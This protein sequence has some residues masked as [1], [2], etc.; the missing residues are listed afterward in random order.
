MPYQLINERVEVRLTARRWSCSTAT[1][2]WR[3]TRAVS[4]RTATPRSRSTGPR[5]TSATWSGRRGGSSIGP[6]RVGAHCAAVVQWIIESKP[7]PEQ[8]YR[9]CLGLLRLSQE[10]WQ[11]A[12]RGRLSPGA[13][14]PDL[15]YRSIKSILA[16]KLDAQPLPQDEAV[17][18]GRRARQRARPRLLQLNQPQ[19]PMTAKRGTRH[20]A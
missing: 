19:S 3:R 16:A 15:H 2:A 5:R 9:S 4:S 14:V 6:G 1:G 8:G 10:L 20:A 13:E 7:H 12:R 17:G 18:P 11:R